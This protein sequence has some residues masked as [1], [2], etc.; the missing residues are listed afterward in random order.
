MMSEFG[1]DVKSE[2][3]RQEAGDWF[4]PGDTRYITT[5]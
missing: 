3:E 2:M 5:F 1:V 4:I